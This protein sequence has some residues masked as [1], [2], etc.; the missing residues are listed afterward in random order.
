MKADFT[1]KEWRTA[2]ARDRVCSRIAW[3]QCVQIYSS[4]T[5]GDPRPCMLVAESG[6]GKKGSASP[7]RPHK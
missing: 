2:D 7:I 5:A 3:P 6:H 4:A 1:E